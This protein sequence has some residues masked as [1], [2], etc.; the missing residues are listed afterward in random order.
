M[1][2]TVKL[3]ESLMLSV[4]VFNASSFLSVSS[5]NHNSQFVNLSICLRLMAATST[6]NENLQIPVG[7]QWRRCCTCALLLLLPLCLLLL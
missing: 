5:S 7:H 2:F 1:S 6:A 3:R 4:I